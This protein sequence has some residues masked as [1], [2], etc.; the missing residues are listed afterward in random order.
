MIAEINPNTKQVSGSSLLPLAGSIPVQIRS[1]ELLSDM[2]TPVGLYLRLRDRFPGA[3]LL[4]SAD[5]TEGKNARSFIALNPTAEIKIEGGK[6]KINVPAC[7]ID[8]NLP[9]DANSNSIPDEFCALFLAEGNV[10][11]ATGFIGFT[12]Y[13]AISLFDDVSL[14]TSNT[15]PQLFYALYRTVLIFDHLRQRLFLTEQ[16]LPGEE[17]AASSMEILIR[18]KDL[19]QFKF[20]V[21]EEERANCTDDAYLKMVEKGIRHCKRGDVFQVVLSRKF[22]QSFQGDEF[23]VYRALRSINP[24]PYMFYADYGNFRIFGS[25]PEAQL[26]ISNGKAVLN[27]IAGTYR[28]GN[29]TEETAALAEQLLNDPKE[30][31][32]HTMLVDLAR[33]DL[34]R[35]A[36]EVRVEAYRQVHQYSHLIHLVSSVTGRLEKNKKPFQVLADTFPAGT[37]SGAPKHRAMQIIAENENEPRGFYGGCIGFIGFDGSLKQAILIRSFLSQNNTLTFQAGAGVVVSSEPQKE[38]EEINHKLAALRKAISV[39]EKMAI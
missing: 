33:N 26:V 13:D 17:S 6:V 8:L 18:S 16:L 7:S 2:F 27:P 32:E 22:R 14:P 36:T 1:R 11:E 25:S 9:V 37:L 15:I 20:S 10:S 28:R 12:S 38:L 19:P 35:S 21:K 29:P 39:A 34:A 23:N 3:V 4:E 5:N 24:S 31:S 30:N